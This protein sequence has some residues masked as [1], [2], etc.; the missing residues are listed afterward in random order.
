MAISQQRMQ[1]KNM[2]ATWIR[3]YFP[4]RHV[5]WFPP[6]ELIFV[7]PSCYASYTISYL[8]KPVSH[9]AQ[10]PE[11]LEIHFPLIVSGF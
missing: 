10:R 7:K 1:H 2:N 6:L 4:S 5:S 3:K 8:T 9:L 11:V